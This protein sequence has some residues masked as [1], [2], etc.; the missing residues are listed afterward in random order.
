[1]SFATREE[2]RIAGHPI[3]LYAFRFGPEAGSIR[4]YTNIAAGFNWGVTDAGQPIFWS[5]LPIQHS[6]VVASGNLDKSTLEVRMPESGDIPDLYSEEQPS[7]VVTLIIRQGHLA[8][9]DF[10]VC[11]SGKVNGVSYEGAELVLDCEPI[12]ASLRRSG[13]TRDYQLSCPLVLYGPECRAN[14]AAATTSTAVVSIDGPIVTLAPTWAASDRKAKYV[15]G[16]AEWTNASG[17]VERRSIIKAEGEGQI[18]L[19]NAAS[20]LLAGMTVNLILGCNHQH[21]M[22]DPDGDCLNLHDNIL[23]FGGQWEIP[24]KNPVG[25]TNN[26]Y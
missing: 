10:K 13:L 21:G 17:R 25:I 22:R 9:D 1:M 16:I 4:R 8:D 14:K 11:W 26:F 3:H 19:S 20:S 7:N 12:S 18:L 23:N 6:D 5:P 2:S 15:G 24:T